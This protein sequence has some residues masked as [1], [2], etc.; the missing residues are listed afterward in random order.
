MS[1]WQ[2]IGLKIGAFIAA[3]AVLSTALNLLLP[4]FLLHPVRLD[5]DYIFSFEQPFEEFFLPSPDGAQINALYFCTASPAR[6]GAVLYFHGNADNLQRWGGFA[7]DFTRRGYDFFV[8]DYRSF[9]KSTGTFSEENCY[10]DARLAHSWLLQKGLQPNQIVLCGRSLGSG[11]ASQLATQVTAKMLLLET[12][13]DNLRSVAVAHAP[14]I[15]W[16]KNFPF[17][18]Q[19]DENLQKI[20]IPVHIFHGNADRIIPYR[21]AAN[22][23]KY[24]KKSDSFN[25]ILGGQHKNLNT[26]EEYQT[27]LDAILETNNPLP[28][29]NEPLHD[30]SN[31]H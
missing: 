18:F 6:K 2:K 22:L 1:S 9:G 27:K 14:F 28:F 4:R 11:I 10:A 29:Q 30:N 24:L 19:N 26:F 31:K 20:N 13:Y 3:S 15:W 21:C 16:E 8:M 12:P 7:S 17:R 23:K 5:A 25:T